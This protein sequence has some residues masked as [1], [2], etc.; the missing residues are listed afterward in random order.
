[1]VWIKPREK[2]QPPTPAT[3]LPAKLPKAVAWPLD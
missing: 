1:M 2:G 3:E